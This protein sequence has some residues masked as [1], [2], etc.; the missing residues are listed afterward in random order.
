MIFIFFPLLAQTDELT[1]TYLLNI[2]CDFMIGRVQINHFNCHEVKGACKCMFIGSVHPLVS[3]LEVKP[4]FIQVWSTYHFLKC[5]TV[6]DRVL[7]IIVI[8]YPDNRI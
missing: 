3:M 7:K 4:H 6:C 5:C 8:S 1:F 2:G